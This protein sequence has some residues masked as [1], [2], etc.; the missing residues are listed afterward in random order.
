MHFAV[1]TQRATGMG[2][3]V[4]NLQAG[5]ALAHGLDHTRRLGTQ[6]R[7]QRWRCIQPAAEVGVDEVQADRMVT[8]SYLLR[9][10]R[11]G[12][13]FHKLQH[14]R[15]AMLAELDTLGHLALL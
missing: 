12:F 8:H 10:G 2:D 13:E 4:A 14:F 15:A 9:P 5:H 11:S 7:G 3:A 1:R 6:P